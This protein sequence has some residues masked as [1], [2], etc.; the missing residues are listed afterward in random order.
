EV[1]ACR[2]DI[3]EASLRKIGCYLGKFVYLMDAFEDVERDIKAGSFNPWKD[4]FSDPCFEKDCH[5]ILTMFISACCREFEKLPIIENVEILRNI[6]YS[7]VWYRY[8]MVIE[9]RRRETGRK[10]QEEHDER[11]I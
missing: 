5:E 3:W 7:G 2:E 11:S 6:L 9:K 1:F 10:K 4:K 8:E